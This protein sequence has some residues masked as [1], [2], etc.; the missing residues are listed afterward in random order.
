MTR[1]S[2]SRRRLAPALIVLGSLLMC[3]VPGQTGH[4]AKAGGTLTIGATSDALTLDPTVTTD[5]ASGPVENLLFN[6]LVKLNDKAQIVPDLASSWTISAAGTTY[7]FHLRSGVMFH[8]GTVMTSSDV[9]ASLSRLRDPSTK[10]PWASFFTDVASVA[11]PNPTTIVIKLSQPYGPF[12]AV[13]ASFLS[14]SS[15]N[16]VTAHKGNLTRVEDGTG[17]YVLKSWVPNTSITLVKNSHYFVAG[18]PHF[19]SVVFQ[20]IPSDA[21]RV[22]ALRTGQIQFA[23]FIDPIYFPQVQQLKSAGQAKIVHVLDINY[24]MFG[25]NTK[26]KPFDNPLVRLAISYAI[27]RGQILKAAGQGQGV[28]S[29]L[30]TPALASWALPVSQYAPYTPNLAKAR[31]LLAQ[32]GYPH[33]FSFSIMASHY[34]PSDYTAAEIIQQQL[35][36]L[37]IKA[38]IATTE[39]GVYVHDWVIR[40]FDSFTGENGDWTDPDLAMYAALHT[41]GSTNAFQF[42][43]PTIDKLLDQARAATSTAARKALYN[44]IQLR[45]V[46]NGGPMVYTYASYWDYAMS[47]NVQ[48]FTYIPR[49]SYQGLIGASFQ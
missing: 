4:A 8:D 21:S 28:V 13:L 3:A 33:G 10:S 18:Q 14:V 23:A 12:L 19:D 6:S 31:Q 27:D 15:A 5:E 17:P 35:A 9:A 34:L 24:H 26:R 25:F 43:D 30:L 32:A 11:T 41:G 49:A 38:T 16:F 48:G 45:L 1:L 47:P 7:T 22:A 46:N 39:W 29:G 37:G 20:V 2:W 36:P 40:N 44:Q 42:S